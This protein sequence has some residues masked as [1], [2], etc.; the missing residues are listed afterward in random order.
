MQ[1]NIRTIAADFVNRNTNRRLFTTV[2]LLIACGGIT[3]AARM[4][5]YPNEGPPKFFGR[6]VWRASVEDEPS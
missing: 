5:R 4:Q 3:P 1:G 2:D 6:M